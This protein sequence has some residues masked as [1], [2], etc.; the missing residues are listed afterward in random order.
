MA[1]IISPSSAPRDDL[2]LGRLIV[3]NKT[4]KGIN[5]GQIQIGKL[6]DFLRQLS[7]LCP[8]DTGP[9]RP[10]VHLQ[11]NLQGNARG[12]CAS[13]NGTAHSIL[14]TAR[15]RRFKRPASAMA[16]LSGNHQP[17]DRR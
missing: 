9:L 14:S 4:L 12:L 7:G 1:S 6:M 11:T 8:L 16:L 2:I 15:I 13:L 3:I 5:T 10:G 17:W